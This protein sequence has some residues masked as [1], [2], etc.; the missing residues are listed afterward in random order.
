MECLREFNLFSDNQIGAKSSAERKCFQIKFFYPI[1][2]LRN[3]W[4]SPLVKFYHK[5]SR[6][7]NFWLL[8]TL[9]KFDDFTVL[10]PFNSWRISLQKILRII[11]T[12]QQDVGTWH[13]A[14]NFAK[15][16]Q[17]WNFHFLLHF[18][19]LCSEK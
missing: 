17:T 5:T 1:K 13:Y 8:L 12:W 10:T 19:R 3:G 11:F 7:S 9:T 14:S 15:I 4:K 18:S 2:F 6:F 16:S